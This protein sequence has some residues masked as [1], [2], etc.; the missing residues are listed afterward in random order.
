MSLGAKVIEKHFTDDTSREGPDHMFSMDPSSWSEMVDRTRELEVALGTG[1][2]RVMEN[3]TETIVLQ[4]RAVRINKDLSVGHAIT[5]EDLSLLR[6]CP[7]N[8]LPPY[9]VN[10]VIGKQIK[11]DLHKD[12]LLRFEDFLN[13]G[14]CHT[15]HYSSIQ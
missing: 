9:E 1:E 8:A 11:N 5:V 2:K 10:N 4:R 14:P 13:D 6:P 3:E 7:V 12:H 15:Y